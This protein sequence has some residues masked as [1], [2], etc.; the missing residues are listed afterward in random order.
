M[1]DRA[2]GRETVGMS[3]MKSEEAEATIAYLADH[4]PDARIDDRGTFYRIEAERCLA[5]DVRKVSE[6]LG[7]DLLLR[8]FLVTVSTYFGRAQVEDD[9]FMISSEML[10]LSDAENQ[11][12]PGISA[13]HPTA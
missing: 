6:Y 11:P 9:V 12:Q 13:Q 4:F 1:T 3:L 10:Q 8:T 2:A 5:V 7:R